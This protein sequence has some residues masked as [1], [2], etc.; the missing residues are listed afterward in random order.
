MACPMSAGLFHDRDAGGRE[1]GHLFGRR[2]FANRV[3][4]R[5]RVCQVVEKSVRV[6]SQPLISF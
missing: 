4:L 3:D 1:R 6:I 5:G 2:G